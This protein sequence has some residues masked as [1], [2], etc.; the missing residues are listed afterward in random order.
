MKTTDQEILRALRK[1]GPGYVS[2]EDLAARLE[3]S[4]AAVWAHVDGL[5]A[6]GLH[7]VAVPHLGYQLVGMD[8]VLVADDFLAQL[9]TQIVGREIIVFAETGSTQDVVGKMAAEGRAAE[10]LVVL[11]ELQKKGRGRQGRPWHSH[12]GKGL[13]FSVL[14][15]PPWPPMAATRLTA[16][17]AVAVA[18]ALERETG[19]RVHIKY[20]NDIYAG[21][22]KLAGIL[23]ELHTEIDRVRF[24][25]V[26]IGI[27][28]N[29]QTGDFS[30]E[31]RGRATSVRMETGR[32][33]L[34]A[35]LAVELLRELDSLYQE[36]LEGH[37]AA[38]T[39][40]WTERCSTLGRRVVV[41]LGATQV[42]GVAEGLDKDGALRVRTGPGRVETVPGGDVFL[43]K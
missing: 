15:R 32:P 7:I 25:I 6:A 42:Q 29:Q 22:S 30:G 11:A 38:I 16:L 14:L 41:R 28:V 2:G 23:T 33:H 19:I 40:E 13:W 34:R 43:E 9:D 1:A 21:D 10:G 39:R 26:G 24:A 17:T 27:N 37:F 31:L 18:R 35:P 20:P 8:D 12:R 36:A 5:R 3:I 4:R